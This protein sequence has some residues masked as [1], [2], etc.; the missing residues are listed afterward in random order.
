MPLSIGHLI[1]DEIKKSRLFENPNVFVKKVNSPK[2]TFISV[3]NMKDETEVGSKT[4]YLDPNTFETQFINRY[5]NTDEMIAVDNQVGTFLTKY[6]NR[7]F[8][9]NEWRYAFTMTE[10]PAKL[11]V[12]ES[13]IDI[14]EPSEEKADA[15]DP[16][17]D[18]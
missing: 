4:F 1:P 2:Q 6:F 7:L 10:D 18:K 15:K 13:I 12:L 17:L 11:K 14:K 16:K 5:D 9:S 3:S 8:A